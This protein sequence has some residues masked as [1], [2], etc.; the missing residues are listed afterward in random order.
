MKLVGRT[1][2]ATFFSFFCF[3]SSLKM[4]VY[5]VIGAKG[6]TGREIVKRLIE[7]P[8]SEVCD[9][10]ASS[11]TCA[12]DTC[13]EQTSTTTISNENRYRKSGRWCEIRAPSL[14]ALCQPTRVSRSLLAMQG[15]VCVCVCACVCT[16]LAFVCAWCL[17]L[18]CLC[19]CVWWALLFYLQPKNACTRIVS[20]ARHHQRPAKRL[21]G[22]ICI[23]DEIGHTFC[24]RVPYR[25]KHKP[26]LRLQK[27]ILKCLYL[28]PRFPST[29]APAKRTRLKRRLQELRQFFSLRQASNSF[30]F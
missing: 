16:V 1:S 13:L 9:P 19:D 28:F 8:A 29:R 3:P 17:C 23:F 15:D 27:N 20:V 7:K 4:A 18:L 12:L 22:Y 25:Q 24:M 10:E 26:N 11:Y 21:Q 30:S 14:K 2:I 5:V 6:G